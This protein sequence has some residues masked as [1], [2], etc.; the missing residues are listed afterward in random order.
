VRLADEVL[1]HLLRHFKI[2][3]HPVAHR[4]DGDDVAGCAAEHLLRVL[5]NSLDIICHLINSDDRWLAQHYPTPFSVNECVGGTQID[6]QV[7]GTQSGEQGEGH[8]DSSVLF[9]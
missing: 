4:P 2:G 1:K 5:T 3:D 9:G 6:G 8:S 7:V